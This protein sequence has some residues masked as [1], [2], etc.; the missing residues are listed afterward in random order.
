MAELH[1][2]TDESFDRD[3][4]ESD[5]PVLVDFWGEHCPPCRAIAP[6]LRELATQYSGRL[7]IVKL[8]SDENG[9]TMV[10]FQVLSLPTVLAF[11]GGR[12]VGQ[13]NGARPRK[14]FQALIER[15][16]GD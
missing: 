15:A 8:N 11:C 6:I 3:V 10:R 4:I 1:D 12:V 13:L 9:N 14:D 7:K 2:V 5:L 16:L